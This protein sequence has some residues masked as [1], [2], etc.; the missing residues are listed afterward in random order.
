MKIPEPKNV[1]YC[2][3]VVEIKSTFP[4]NKLDNLVG[5]SIMGNITLIPN[6]TKIGAKGVFFPVE[7]RLSDEFLSNNNLYRKTELN[8]DSTKKGYFELNGRVRC[9]KFMGNPSEGIFMEMECLKYLG[10]DDLELGMSFDY[11]GDNKIC[12]KYVVITSVPGEPNQKKKKVHSKIIQE[13]FKFHYDT[14]HL[15]KYVD[16]IQPGD[17][18]SVTR[19][20]HGSSGISAYIICK[21]PLSLW[22][23]IGKLLGFNV[24]DKQ[25]DYV[26]SSRKVIK[27]PHLNPT[28]SHFY[29]S[30]IW[31]L[32][33]DKI[34]E[35][36][37]KGMTFYYEIVGYTSNGKMMQ[38]NYDYG[39]SSGEFEV[40]IYRITYTNADGKNFEFSMKQVQRFCELNG[41]K[42]VPELYYG[43]L[44]NLLPEPLTEESI[45]EGLRLA[46]LEGDCEYSNNTVPAEGIVIRNESK[47]YAVKA[48]KY[49]SLRFKEYETKQLDKGEVDIEEAY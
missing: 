25:Y 40:Y 45:L 34:K 7:C 17:I 16:E 18:I 1:N 3:T 19:K 36:L 11:I 38:K 20:L 10:V 46:Y 23:R 13:Q 28:A 42:V 30:N 49:K 8:K 31:A 2:G 12:E 43:K 41:L 39:C 22:D 35:Y 47:P 4:L 15:G 29:G 27:N 5:A 48:L 9:Q 44:N 24:M 6:N 21:K 37:Q 14:E 32:A 33:H 26:Y